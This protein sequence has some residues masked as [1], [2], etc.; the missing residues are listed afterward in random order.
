MK[1]RWRGS[2]RMA[3]LGATLAA[4]VVAGGVTPMAMADNSGRRFCLYGYS[5]LGNEQHFAVVDY[6]NGSWGADSGIACPP[7]NGTAFLA[8]INWDSRKGSYTW[9]N[10]GVA[11]VTCE[12]FLDQY[13][14]GVVPA[15]FQEK[16]RDYFCDN[17]D[18]DTLY[19]FLVT[20]TTDA[21][22][23]SHVEVKATKTNVKT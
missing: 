20:T 15:D 5:L 14:K 7:A 2:R 4:I 9:R 16:R 11:K 6:K 21:G 23:R 8:A 1:K 22:G 13:L 18:D 12:D 19:E 10:Y 17:T 3:A